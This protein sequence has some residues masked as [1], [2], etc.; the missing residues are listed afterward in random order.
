M[1]ITTHFSEE[2]FTKSSTADKHGIDN[3]IP[4]GSDV[5]ANIHALCD[6]VLEKIREE[7]G[8]VRITSGYRC[9][10][11]NRKL[12]SK[13]TSQHVI[14]EAADIQ[15]LD[16]DLKEAFDKIRLKYEFDQ[17]IYEV[18]A[19][20]TKWIHISWKHTGVNRNEA[21]LAAQVNGKM[22]YSYA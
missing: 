13:D 16:H 8:C 14:G 5:Q 9:V 7:F 20:G 17:A 21:L 15:L 1:K 11:L 3:S 4:D 12:V 2:E 22:V 19:S 10:N 18:K 6:N